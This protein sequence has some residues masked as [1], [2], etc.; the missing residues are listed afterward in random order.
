MLVNICCSP[1]SG[2]TLFSQILDRHA[3][4][5]CG[6][7]LWLFCKPLLYDDYE[8]L[9]RQRWWVRAFGLSG[10]PYH[11]YRDVFRHTGGY[12]MHKATFWR[13]VSHAGDLRTL[14]E[15]MKQHV[16]QVTGRPVWAEKT[17][18]NIRVIGRFLGTFPEARVIHIVRDVRDVVLSF[19]RKKRCRDVLPG[20]AVWLA[21]VAAIQPHR[22]RGNVLEIRY[23]DLCTEPEAT[24]RQVCGFLEVG[25]DVRDLRGDG[26]PS[27]LAKAKGHPRWS[28]QP[29]QEVSTHSVARHRRS[30]LDWAFLADLR[31]T[32]AYADLLGTRQW[33]AAELARS[34]GYDVPAGPDAPTARPYQPLQLARPLSERMGWLDRRVGIP[35]YLPQVECAVSEEPVGAESF[36]RE[37]LTLT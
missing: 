17:P 30:D 32:A 26:C 16:Q 37:E 11:E 7:E 24:L 33:S 35:S 2:S 20:A 6:D 4:I 25:F 34:Y 9:R 1:S 27:A 31:V 22:R 5:A 8:R 29:N 12:R 3:Q 13:W 15:R 36:S 23:E 28:L 18:W 19:R 10:R 14:A 21:S